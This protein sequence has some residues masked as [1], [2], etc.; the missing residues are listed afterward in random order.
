MSQFTNAQNDLVR[1]IVAGKCPSSKVPAELHKIEQAFPDE[2]FGL[3]QPQRKEKPWD[4]SYLKELEQ[5][6][7]YGADS[8]EFI[9][10]MAE[11]SDEVYRAKRLRK[12]LLCALLV[13]AGIAVIVTLVKALLGD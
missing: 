7:Y 6:F 5:L 9:E 1:K 12:Y 10:Y 13:L 8:K 2:S 11:V 4:M 3:T